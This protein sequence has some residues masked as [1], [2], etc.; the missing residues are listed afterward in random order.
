MPYENAGFLKPRD[1]ARFYKEGDIL[2]SAPWYESSP[3]FVLEAMAC[4]L[5]VITTQL[6]TEDYAFAGEAPEVVEARNPTS[7]AN[8]L[9]RLIT[10]VNYRNRIAKSGPE[11]ARQFTWEKSV[12]TMEGLL[13]DLS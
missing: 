11:I 9:I 4:G 10:D 12:A 7:I 3:L 13:L 2:L 5:P 6:G 1:L 8:G